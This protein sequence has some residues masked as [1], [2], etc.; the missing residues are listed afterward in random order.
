VI[1]VRGPQVFMEHEFARLRSAIDVLEE[2]YKEE[3]F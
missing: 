1:A 2:K 3:K